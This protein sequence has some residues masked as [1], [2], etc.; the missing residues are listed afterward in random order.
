MRVVYNP[1]SE[2]WDI[3]FHNQIGGSAFYSGVPFRRG[4]FQQGA[5]LGSILTSAARYLIPIAIDTGKQIGQEGLAFGSRVLGKLA[6]GEPL[7]TTLQQEGKK[8]LRNLAQKAKFQMGGS[9]RRKPKTSHSLI[10]KKLRLD[11]AINSSPP[12]VKKSSKKP[13]PDPFA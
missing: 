8:S 6:E 7:K 11:A 10:G 4:N 12:F 5:G 1:D 3:F 13:L 9:K 2:N